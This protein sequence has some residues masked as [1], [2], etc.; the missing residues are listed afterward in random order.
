[1]PL[2]D[3]QVCSS[4]GCQFISE[5]LCRHCQ[6]Q[7]CYLCFMSHRKSLLNDMKS[8]SDQMSHNRQ[9]GTNEV[10]EFINKQAQ[11]AHDQTTQLINDAIKRIKQRSEAIFKYIEYR[12][13]LK[14][15]FRLL[16]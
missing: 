3:H 8:I 1:M 7:Y 14:A 11:D 6:E 13:Q 12:R 16:I 9:Q 15:S 5:L 4:S 2:I 10:V